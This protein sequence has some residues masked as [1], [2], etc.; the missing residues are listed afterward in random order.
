MAAVVSGPVA[1]RLGLGSVLGYLIVGAVIG[2]FAPSPVGDQT[3]FSPCMVDAGWDNRSA[4]G[5]ARSE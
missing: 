4:I 1:K 3:D 5:D 2:P